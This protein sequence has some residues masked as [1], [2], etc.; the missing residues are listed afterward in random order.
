MQNWN[1]PFARRSV[2]PFVKVGLSA[3]GHTSQQ[4][5]LP[6]RCNEHRRP[7]FPLGDSNTLPFNTNIEFGKV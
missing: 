6:M 1:P 5:H 3:T 4:R 7:I 2:K